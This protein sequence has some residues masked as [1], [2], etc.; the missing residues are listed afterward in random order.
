MPNK[1]IGSNELPQTRKR[2]QMNRIGGAIL[3]G[4]AGFVA[5]T[6]ASSAAWK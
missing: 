6:A 3:L 2:G 1:L 5:I 4:L